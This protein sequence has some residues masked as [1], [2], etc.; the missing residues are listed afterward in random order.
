MVFSDKSTLMTSQHKDLK[1]R[2]NYLKN[3]TITGA[4]DLINKSEFSK[5]NM[6]LI[7]FFLYCLIKMKAHTYIKH[8][9]SLLKN[10]E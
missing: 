10:L 3:A 5:K 9:N 8:N 2:H 6:L 1:S 7:L 4:Y